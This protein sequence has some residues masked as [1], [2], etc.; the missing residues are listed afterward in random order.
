MVTAVTINHEHQGLLPCHGSLVVGEGCCPAKDM[1]TG[2]FQ[3]IGQEAESELRIG[4]CEVVVSGAC[5]SRHGGTY[6]AKVIA[7]LF[8]RQIAGDLATPFSDKPDS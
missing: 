2:H 7:P 3:D 1:H 6:K 8:Y 4:A 5:P